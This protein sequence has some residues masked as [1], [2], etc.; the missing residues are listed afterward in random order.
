MKPSR[1]NQSCRAFTLVEVLVVIVV[2]AV[3]VAMLLPAFNRSHGGQTI[4]CANN[5]KQI[6]LSYRLWA[7]DNND[8]YPMEISVTNG[9]AMELMNTPDA[10]KVFQ[11]MSN[12]LS[13]PKILY[14]P[15]DSAHQFYTNRYP[16][17]PGFGDDLKIH[18]S[19]FIGRDA[20]ETNPAAIL[21]GDDN[22]EINGI[23][24]KTG[25]L[26]LSK[27]TSIAWT[28]ARHTT[29]KRHFWNDAT[30]FGNVGL[31]DGSVQQTTISSRTNFVQQ[32]NG[33]I[34]TSLTSVLQA[35]GL[36]TN[37]LAIP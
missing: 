14:C 12:E 28:S 27:D 29:H 32:S 26:E 2:L 7:G 3:M 22:F 21:S 10:W 13:T 34:T 8:H 30:S 23:P 16:N 1:S 15:E 31:A 17:F 4:S 25:L 35:T 37:R 11:V 6:G 9:G 36:A 20:T 18:L 5:L 24:V 19:Y 33:A